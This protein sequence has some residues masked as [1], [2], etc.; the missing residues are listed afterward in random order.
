MFAPDGFAVGGVNLFRDLGEE[1]TLEQL[2][3][4]DRDRTLSARKKGHL[5]QKQHIDR[6]KFTVR[7][8]E[9]FFEKF[10]ILLL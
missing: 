1:E 4:T 9:Y 5:L 8:R 7:L 3:R 6:D 2:V 10:F